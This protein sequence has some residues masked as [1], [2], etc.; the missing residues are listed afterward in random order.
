MKT[1]LIKTRERDLETA[2]AAEGPLRGRNLV[3]ANLIVAAYFVFWIGRTE[4]KS[5]VKRTSLSECRFDPYSSR[6]FFHHHFCNVE[7]E[8]YAATVLTVYL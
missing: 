1:D 3:F 7:S 8:S 6:M 2:A 5:E 4:R